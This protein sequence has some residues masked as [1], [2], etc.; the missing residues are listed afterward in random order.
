MVNPFRTSNIS[1]IVQGN[2]VRGVGVGTGRGG[3]CWRCTVGRKEFNNNDS[4]RGRYVPYE[5]NVITTVYIDGIWRGGGP[6]REF[7]ILRTDGNCSVI[8][9]KY[10]LLLFCH[11]V[12]IG[13]F[14][15]YSNILI[16]RV[17]KEGLPLLSE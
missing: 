12:F 2:R 14:R 3:G 6:L 11:F 5:F 9:K 10:V 1:C 16:H 8:Y 4:T 15:S 7:S 17:V 13:F